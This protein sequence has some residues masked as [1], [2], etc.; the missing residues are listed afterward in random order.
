M[1]GRG[2]RGASRGR[3][4]SSRQQSSPIVWAIGGLSLGLLVALLVWINVNTPETTDSTVAAPISTAPV[5]REKKRKPPEPLDIPEPEKSRFDFY[6]DLKNQRVIVPHTDNHSKTIEA[7]P[8][9]LPSKPASPARG[10]RYILQAGSFRK[11]QQAEQ[12]KARLALLGIPA[13]IEKV[14]VSD[15]IWHR[16]RLGP[17]ANIDEANRTR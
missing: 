16:V 1:A 4:K 15:G 11:H 3:K 7:G 13:K 8:L 14:R 12:M 6:Q 10:Q 2:K 9:L 5:V 17:Y